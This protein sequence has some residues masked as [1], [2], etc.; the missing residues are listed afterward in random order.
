MNRIILDINDRKPFIPAVSQ[1]TNYFYGT[2]EA[3]WTLGQGK[4]DTETA[5]NPIQVISY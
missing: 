4:M 5:L 1:N 3:T 2:P